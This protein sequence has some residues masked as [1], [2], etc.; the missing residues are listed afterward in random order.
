MPATNAKNMRTDKFLPLMISLIQ[1]VRNVP[2]A[3]FLL[4]S[5]LGLALLLACSFGCAPPSSREGDG[6]QSPSASESNASPELTEELIRERINDAGVREVPEENGAAE[7][8]N[9]SF[10]E[11]EPKE[12]TV[13][14]KQ[15]DGVRATLLLDI[16]TGSAS[17]ARNPCYLA[18]QIRTEWELKT[19]WV[20]RRWEIV[21]TEN[22]SMKYR[23]LPKPP[24]QNS[25]R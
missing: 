23:N 1:H 11:N 15:V 19:G 13:I 25:N 9:W 18:G 3:T 5:F 8:I 24:A 7:P 4:S 17:G 6:K 20:L 10:D 22:I 14:E 2:R 16:K 12:I 21:R